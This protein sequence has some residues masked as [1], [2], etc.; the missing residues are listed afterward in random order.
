V[1]LPEGR[2]NTIVEAVSP[3]PLQDNHRPC[4]CRR[5][6][7]E[8]DCHH[9]SYAR[10]VE[11]EWEGL[12]QTAAWS[13]LRS[14][15]FRGSGCGRQK[16][17]KGESQH[18]PKEKERLGKVLRSCSVLQ[19]VVVGSRGEASLYRDEALMYVLHLCEYRLGN[20]EEA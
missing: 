11:R 14:G 13:G 10:S 7:Q 4:S 19:V 8:N 6:T 5:G 20:G 2:G 15:A 17:A 1:V 18:V 9:T 16:R 3:A 12:G